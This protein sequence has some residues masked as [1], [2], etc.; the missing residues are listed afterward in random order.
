MKNIYICF[1][2]GKHKVLTM[3]YDDGKID[4]YRLVS[5]F[6]ENG[7]KGTFHL[8]SQLPMKE[9]IPVSEYKKLYISRR[10]RNDCRGVGKRRLFSR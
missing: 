1:P 9:R 10:L 8:N 7:I 2:G 5:I 6:N 3:S 4:D